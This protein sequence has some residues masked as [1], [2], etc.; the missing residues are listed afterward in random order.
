M[1]CKGT[2]LMRLRVSPG[3]TPLHTSGFWISPTNAGAAP[4]SPFLSEGIKDMPKV[5]TIKV[6]LNSRSFQNNVTSTIG[7]ESK[8]KEIQ[9]KLEPIRREKKPQ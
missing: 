9:W 5:G 1:P 4:N 2:P 8:A 3:N 7:E 6:K